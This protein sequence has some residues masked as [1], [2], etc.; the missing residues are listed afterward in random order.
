MLYKDARAVIACVPEYNRVL[1][2]NP[3]RTYDQLSDADQLVI[4]KAIEASKS[5]SEK[6]AGHHVFQPDL[7]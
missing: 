7:I 6:M 4:N 5:F 2:N 1:L 3:T